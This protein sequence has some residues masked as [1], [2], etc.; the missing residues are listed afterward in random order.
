MDIHHLFLA[1][2]FTIAAGVNNLTLG[3]S[4]SLCLVFSGPARESSEKYSHVVVNIFI[5]P[6]KNILEASEL[7][8]P[9]YKGK[10]VG[11]NSVHY[12]GIPLYSKALPIQRGGGGPGDLESEV[13]YTEHHEA[14]VA[15]EH[16]VYVYRYCCLL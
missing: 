11:P 9:H 1:R 12:R 2:L 6:T 14:Q 7:G 8:T 15:I 3:H 13:H 16:V 10:I 5:T 4:T